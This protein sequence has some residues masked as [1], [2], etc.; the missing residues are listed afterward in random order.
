LTPIPEDSDMEIAVLFGCAVTTGFGVVSNNAQLKIGESVVIFGAGGIGL[1]IVQAAAL[2]SANPIIAVDVHNGRLDLAEKL[3]A[4]HTI[5]A[6]NQDTRTGIAH[7]LG[8][9]LLD[10]FIDNTGAAEVIQ[11]GYELTHPQGRIV[12]V[13][14]PPEGHNISIYSLP[15]HFGK[16]ITGSHGGEAIPHIDIPRYYR[17]YRQG[18]LKLKALVS[19]TL[20][21][22]EINEAIAGMRDG[23]ISGRCII[24]MQ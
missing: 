3:G 22:E 9:D 4:T 24:S 17:L 6:R 11:M 13:G 5:N 1:N 21:L 14:V 18:R 10:V 23:S 8:E 2:A 20:R 15:L 7:V 16:R 19:R 12:L